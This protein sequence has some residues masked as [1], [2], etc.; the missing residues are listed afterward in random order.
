MADP[1]QAKASG[2]TTGKVLLIA[3]LALTLVGVL[4]WQFG[5]SE[6]TAALAKTGGARRRP[7]AA[8]AQP[9]AATTIAKKTQSDAPLAEM[10]AVVDPSRWKS[11][12]LTEIVS[13]DPLAVPD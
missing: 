4:Y 6:A 13:F 10:P 5:T 7:A 12:P 8:P 3:V 1:K 11:P 9:A 2:L